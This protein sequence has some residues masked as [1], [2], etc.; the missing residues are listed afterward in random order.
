M[1]TSE[2][3]HSQQLAVCCDK[4]RGVSIE[5]YVIQINCVR[6]LEGKVQLNDSEEERCSDPVCMCV[7]CVCGD[8]SSPRSE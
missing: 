2:V 8:R 3:I 7:V 6:P 1:N 4:D 5:I